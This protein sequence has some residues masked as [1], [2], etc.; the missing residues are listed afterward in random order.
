MTRSIA[1]QKVIDNYFRALCQCS[2]VLSLFNCSGKSV[3]NERNGDL[4]QESTKGL[5]GLQ[6]SPPEA[7]E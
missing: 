1:E 3:T 4:E 7:D 6:S 2:T 5:N